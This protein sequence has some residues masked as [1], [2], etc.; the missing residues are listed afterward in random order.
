MVRETW[1]Q[2]RVKSYQ[3]LKW[4]LIPPC[5]TLSNIRYVLRVKWSNPGKG[6]ASSP[7]PR[8]NSYWKGNVLVA[9]DCGRQQLVFFKTL[10]DL[11]QNI[12]YTSRF[13]FIIT[14]LCWWNVHTKRI[15]IG[16][17]LI[18]HQSSLKSFKAKVKFVRK[19]MAIKW[20][21]FT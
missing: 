5:L 17:I 9:L 6:V 15:P 18:F 19:L 10:S 20:T 21:K 7:I 11:T 2:S 13:C 12:M 1:V 16:F 14:F 4:Y 3:R 8:C